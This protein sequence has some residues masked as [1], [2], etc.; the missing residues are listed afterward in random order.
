MVAKL[1][2]NGFGSFEK[3]LIFTVPKPYSE[4]LI[5]AGWEVIEEE[6][7]GTVFKYS[8]TGRGTGKNEE[9]LFELG[10]ELFG[11]VPDDCFEIDWE[12]SVY[13]VVKSVLM[14]AWGH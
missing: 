8:F 7:S 11:T 5:K 3:H 13:Y 2:S 1:K 9:A 10:H 4:E 6:T 14:S 12:R